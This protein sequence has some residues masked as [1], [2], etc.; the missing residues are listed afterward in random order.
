MLEECTR[1]VGLGEQDE[2]VPPEFKSSEKH[3]I[4][5]ASI[6]SR[7]EMVTEGPQSSSGM[8]RK[9]HGYFRDAAKDQEKEGELG[10]KGYALF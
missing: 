2:G 6:T 10:R 5:G 4:S 9:G 3:H 7:T 1:K 8:W